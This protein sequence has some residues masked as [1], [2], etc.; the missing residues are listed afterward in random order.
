MEYFRHLSTTGIMACLMTAHLNSTD[1]QP[2]EVIG[3]WS[4][5]RGIRPLLAQ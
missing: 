3:Q 1:E 4:R 2:R 5:E